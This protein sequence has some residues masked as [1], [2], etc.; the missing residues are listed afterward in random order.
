MPRRRQGDGTYLDLGPG[1]ATL[2]RRYR[3]GG[4]PDAPVHPD[5]TRPQLVQIPDWSPT[6]MTSDEYLA[7]LAADQWLPVGLRAE[8]P[9]AD[10][11]ARFA[12]AAG[13]ACNRSQQAADV[14]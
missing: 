12:R 10:C 3:D 13:D 14:A 1:S 8:R 9:C 5:R 4:L 7:W 6:C 11:P 2:Y